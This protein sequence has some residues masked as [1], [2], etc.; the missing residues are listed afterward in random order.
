MSRFVANQT[1]PRVC[2][3]GIAELV[4][5]GFSPSAL[6]TSRQL[7]NY[8]APTIV[9]L[10]RA[11]LGVTAARGCAIKVPSRV[12]DQGVKK[13]GPI[14]VVERMQH[15]LGPLSFCGWRQL[16]DRAVAINATSLGCAVEITCSI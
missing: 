15:P 16:E 9:V 6:R 10:V 7:E 1:A 3:V 11:V 8:A 4:Q 13:I 12:Q 2:S 5:Y 14:A